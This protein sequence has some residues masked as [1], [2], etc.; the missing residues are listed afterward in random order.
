MNKLFA[1]CSLLFFT[2]ISSAFADTNYPNQTVRI[3]V[4]LGVGGPT[5]V[6]ARIVFQSVSEQLK[7]KFI[8]ENYPGGASNIGTVM[9]AKARPD[10][11]T[12]LAAGEPLIYNP[13][14]FNNPPFDPIK[15]FEYIAFV[16]AAPNMV[17]VHPDSDIKSMADLK[18]T[19]QQAKNGL[20]YAH[21]G[22]G[23]SSYFAAE[24]LK[25]AKGFNITPVPYAG[26]GP[27][28]QG[29]LRKDTD[30]GIMSLTPI[31]SHI[32]EGKL[33][34]IAVSGEKRLQD[35]PNVPTLKELGYENENA[36][37]KLILLAPAGTPREIIELLN[38]AINTSLQNNETKTRL[39]QIGFITV[40]GSSD[41]SKQ[42]VMKDIKFWERIV[43]QYQIPKINY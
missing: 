40:G 14:L 32:K 23:T 36:D 12:L 4:P 2:L 24:I 34:A 27:A 5:D 39:K 6:A 15:D 1:V 13:V 21:P 37:G 31:V 33:R 26:S 22:V 20:T 30:I 19:S 7:G 38:K 43:D 10:G 35:F 29:M 3:I 28:A 9:V 41:Y 16:A 8:V 17:V 42:Y 11:Y 25:R 18:K